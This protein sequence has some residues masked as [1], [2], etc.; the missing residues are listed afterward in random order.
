MKRILIAVAALGL[1]TSGAQAQ[2]AMAADAMAGPALSL[3]G[4]AALARIWASHEKTDD[5]SRVALRFRFDVTFKG[6]G[7]A[8]GGLTFGGETAIETRGGS[9][10]ASSGLKDAPIHIGGE[11]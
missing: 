10:G 8:D 3:S 2:D 4:S 11:M 1:M 5:E 6:G 7:V 9:S